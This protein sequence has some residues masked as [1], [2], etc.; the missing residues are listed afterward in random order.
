MAESLIGSAMRQ[1]GR[2]RRVAVE[3]AAFEAAELGEGSEEIDL[4]GEF[5][6]AGVVEIG[7]RV[8]DEAG[9]AQAGVET[10]LL[11]LVLLLGE[12]GGESGDSHGVAA[13]GDGANGAAGLDEDV[14]FDLAQLEAGAGKVVRRLD[15]AGAVAA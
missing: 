10:G 4:R 11:E 3:A 9:G 2:R 8:E 15:Q 6:D 7:L 12:P 1:S 5:V 13:G 14:L